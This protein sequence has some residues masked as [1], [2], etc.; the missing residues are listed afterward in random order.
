RHARHR[1]TLA[2]VGC[3]GAGSAGCPAVGLRAVAGAAAGFTDGLSVAR[4][5][6]AVQRRE[7]SKPGEERVSRQ[8][9]ARIANATECDRRVRRAP[10]RRFLWRS[11]PASG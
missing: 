1:D 6:A 11:L 10:A 5:R 2:P 7:A 4:A 9:L 3:L 8:R